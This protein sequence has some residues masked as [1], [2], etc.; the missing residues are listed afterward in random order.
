MLNEGC[1]RHSGAASKRPR[2]TTYANRPYATPDKPP[3][4]GADFSTNCATLPGTAI[5]SV[6]TEQTNGTG[7]ALDATAELD[8]D[9]RIEQQMRDAEMDEDRRDQPPHLAARERLLQRSDTA[10]RLRCPPP[11]RS[12]ATAATA[13]AIR[14]RGRTSPENTPATAPINMRHD[15]IAA[16]QRRATAF[17]RARGRGSH[18]S[19]R[20]PSR[21]AS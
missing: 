1:T 9:R 6:S 18:C 15:R 2:T 13:R 11:A 7:A 14:N 5:S 17:V 10:S 21:H 8:D 19:A 20:R 12:S 4:S 16:Q 3:N